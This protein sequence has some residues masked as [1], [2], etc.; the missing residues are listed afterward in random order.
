MTSP[1]VFQK[2]TVSITQWK[3]TVLWSDEVVILQT[4]CLLRSVTYIGLLEALTKPCHSFD[5][6]FI[7]SFNKIC[8]E[9]LLFASHYSRHCEEPHRE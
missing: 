7:C 4:I 3:K 5:H 9:C 1:N 8:I 2:T 6:L